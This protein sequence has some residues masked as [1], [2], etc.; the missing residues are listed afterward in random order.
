MSLYINICEYNICE[1]Q[2]GENLEVFFDPLKC[3]FV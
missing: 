2:L 1:L 3:I